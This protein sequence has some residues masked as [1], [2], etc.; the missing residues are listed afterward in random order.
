ME[1]YRIFFISFHFYFYVFWTSCAPPNYKW[2]II[3]KKTRRIGIKYTRFFTMPLVFHSFRRNGLKYCGGCPPF[4]L[5]YF[6]SLFVRSFFFGFTKV[7]GWVHQFNGAAFT[8]YTGDLLFPSVEYEIFSKSLAN[9]L[10]TDTP[11][12]KTTIKT[13]A[14][15]A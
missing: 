2:N 15:K 8:T 4:F 14:N 1:K 12:V 10:T 3:I 6:P 5:S 7:F 11:K 9:G 13:K